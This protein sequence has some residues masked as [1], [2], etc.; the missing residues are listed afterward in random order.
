MKSLPRIA[1][2]YANKVVGKSSL[3]GDKIRDRLI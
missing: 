3:L 1:P 2:N